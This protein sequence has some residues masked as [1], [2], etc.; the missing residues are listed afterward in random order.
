MRQPSNYTK[1]KELKNID[2]V[3]AQSIIF[4]KKF[5]G[6]LTSLGQTRA[7]DVAGGDG[8]VT[9]ALLHD[10]FEA[11]DMFDLDQ[12]V[13]EKVDKER[14]LLPKLGRVDQATIQ[15]YEFKK[16]Y[17]L[18]LMCWC[19]GYPEDDELIAFLSKAKKHLIPGIKGT[20]RKKGPVS[21]IVVL[22]NV[23]DV[24]EGTRDRYGQLVRMES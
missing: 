18:I 7:L 17:N 22:E 13:V 5:L 3:H 8:R 11:V 1:K 15:A 14:P 23:D 10:D 2:K 9:K 19:S 20:R 12:K 6:E 4:M 24:G 21:F 16:K